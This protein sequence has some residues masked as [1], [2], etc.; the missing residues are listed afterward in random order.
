MSMQSTRLLWLRLVL[1]LTALITSAGGSLHAQ[2]IAI[3]NVT[4]IDGTGRPAV[5]GASVLIEGNRI[6]GVSA[7]PI[8][9]PAGAHRVDGRGKY[10]IPG[11]MDMHVHLR[12]GRGSG[13]PDETVGI[14]HLQSYIYSGVTTVYDAGNEPDFIVSLRDQERG[15]R[16]VSPRIF[17]TTGIVTYPGSHGS[18]AGATLVDSWPEA[19]PKLDAHIARQPDI[20]KLTYE[21]RGWG[22]RPMIPRLPV[23]LMQKII[24][25]YNNHG[26]RTTVHTSSELQARDAIF[27][28]IDTLAHPVIQGPV[29]DDFVQLMAAKKVPMVSTLTIGEGYSRLAENPGFLDQPLYRAVIEPEEIQRLKVEESAVQRENRWAWWMKIMTPVCQENLRR[30]HEGGG[31]V[32][33]GTDQSIGPAVHR[34]MELLVAAGISP[35]DVIMIGTRHAALFLG[36]ERELGT[37]EEGKLADVVLLDAD[38]SADIDNAKKINLVIKDGRIV[39]RSK[40]D[41]PVNRGSE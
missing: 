39:D 31:I 17:A 16:I 34:E 41:L 29:S 5:P 37:I 38:P 25:H 27:A 3:E 33:L 36:M 40:L 8:E 14:R 13:G 21:E 22:I 35:L 6:A 23:E 15:G 32:A 4:L 2:V 20:L 30:I 1:L 9:A 28:G 7:Q 11:L 26:I 18:G 12:G 19:I 24:H 10:L